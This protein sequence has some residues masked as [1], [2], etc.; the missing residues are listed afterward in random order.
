MAN[1][2]A[3]TIVDVTSCPGTDTCKLGIASSRGL[4]GELRTQL[5]LKSLEMDEAIK[6]LRIKV[7]GCFNS[8]GQHHIADI[9]FYGNS[10]TKKG[11][12]IPHFQVVLG[13]KW[14]QNGGSYGM[15]MGA[16]PSQKIPEVVTKITENF[17]KEKQHVNELFQD[18][19]ERVGKLYIKSLIEEFMFIPD[20][21]DDM[22]YYSDWGDPREF[23]LKDMGIGECAGEIVK[24]EEFELQTAEREVFEAQLSLDENNYKDANNKSY[25]AM[26]KAARALIRID[27]YDVAD[28][29]EIIVQEFKTRFFDNKR[30]FD[31][32]AKGK[33]G[34]YL[35]QRFDETDSEV[36]E[37]VARRYVEESQLFIEAAHSCYARISRGEV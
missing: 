29:P 22:S 4:A 2:G 34:R 13:G 16:V 35:L 10:R 18:Y 24:R 1:P 6:G 23:S 3:G 9:G 31:K 17:I 33:F 27:N 28:S 32:Y 5:A 30:F 11:Y 14:D 25:Q 12:K 20:Y 7:S 8:C 26:L 36:I 19:I 21:K 37:D 15:A